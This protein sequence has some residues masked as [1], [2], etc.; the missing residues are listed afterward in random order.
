MFN[1]V[2]AANI[3]FEEEGGYENDPIHISNSSADSDDQG[4]ISYICSISSCI[5]GHN[6]NNRDG[7]VLVES[8]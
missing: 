7:E 2:E 1:S 8:N 3:D 4:E 5:V 6:G